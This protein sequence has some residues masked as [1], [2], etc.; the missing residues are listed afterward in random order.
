M[1]D[2]IGALRRIV[3]FGF[4]TEFVTANTPPTLDS[5]NA[6]YKSLQRP[7]QTKNDIIGAWIVNFSFLN[8]LETANTQPTLSVSSVSG[9]VFLNQHR[10][11]PNNS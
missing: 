1:N 11:K 5:T 10:S 3:N 7:P 8:E 2:I 4:L 9:V 6:P